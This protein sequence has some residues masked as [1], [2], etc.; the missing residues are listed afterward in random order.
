MID[1]LA[2]DFEMLLDFKATCTKFPDFSYSENVDL[3]VLA[4]EMINLDLPAA[5]QWKIVENYMKGKYQVS[6]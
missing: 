6:Q 2:R 4:K 1:K 3:R 5:D